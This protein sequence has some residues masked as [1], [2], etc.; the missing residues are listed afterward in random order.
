MIPAHYEGKG[1]RLDHGS[2]RVFHPPI[3]LFS[4]PGRHR[5]VTPVD[6]REPLEDVDPE[7]RVVRA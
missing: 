7:R 1:H 4:V 2:Q 3:G 5:K 6:R